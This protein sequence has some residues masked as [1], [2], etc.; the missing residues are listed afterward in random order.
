MA[1]SIQEFLNKNY[2][3][4]ISLEDV[5][6]RFFISKDYASH[7]FKEHTGS[8]LITYV[9]QKRMEKAEELLASTNKPI[10]EIA[11][12]MGYNDPNYFSFTFKKY[13]DMTPRQYRSRYREKD[14]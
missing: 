12:E 11:L 10:V 6:K 4:A 3:S 5:A 14:E 1:D 8:P 13:H 7:I 2:T 9:I